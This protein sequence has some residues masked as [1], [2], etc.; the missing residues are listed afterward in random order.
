[1]RRLCIEG[2]RTYLGRSRGD[3]RR[4]SPRSVAACEL[5]GSAHC[6]AQCLL[7][8][9]R[10]SAYGLYGVSLIR[11]TARCGPACRVVW[12]GRVGD[13]S[14]Y[15][16]SDENQGGILVM[17]KGISDRRSETKDVVGMKLM[18]V[19]DEVV[20]HLGADEHIAP[21]V[22]TDSEARVQ[23]EMIAVQVGAAA[24]G[25]ERARSCAI[26]EQG[27]DTGSG[28]DVTVCLGCQPARVDCIRTDQNWAIELEI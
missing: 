22:V 7:C 25:G 23:E 16:D 15:A 6:P 14:P 13:H 3:D 10:T 12:Q 17:A 1:M 11:R 9:A 24:S 19:G 28:H 18:I 21:G 27:R 4:E 2:G 8:R 26:E 5:V 20:M